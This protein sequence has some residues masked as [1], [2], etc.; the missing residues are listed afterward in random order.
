MADVHHRKKKKQKVKRSVACLGYSAFNDGRTPEGPRKGPASEYTFPTKGRT[1]L[2]EYN[3]DA[4]NIRR[5]SMY[6]GK[7][8]RRDPNNDQYGQKKFSNEQKKKRKRNEGAGVPRRPRRQPRPHSHVNSSSRKIVH[9]AARKAAPA[10]ASNRQSNQVVA[11]RCWIICISLAGR[12]WA[13]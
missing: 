3:A 12:T 10:S 6:S 9:K 11:T 1:K 8:G 7:K 5:H 2:S 4:N 13:R